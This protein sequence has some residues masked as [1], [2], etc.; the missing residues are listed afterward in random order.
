MG[1]QEIFA[2]N[3]IYHIYNR[4]TRKSKIFLDEAD[5]WRWGEL[6]WWCKT[7]NYPY[8]IYRYQLEQAKRSGRDP[9]EI[10]EELDRTNKFAVAPVQ[11]LAFAHMPNH[12]HLL[13]KQVTDEGITQFMHRVGTAYAAYFNRRYE[14]KGALYEGTFK[15][16]RM[17][18]DEQFLQV[19]RYIHLNPLAA[20]LVEKEELINYPKTSL[21]VYLHR[22]GSK[23]RVVDTSQ[24]LEVFG[25]NRKEL[26]EFTLAPIDERVIAELGSLTLDDDFGWYQEQRAR[27][28]QRQAE[29]VDR[30][31]RS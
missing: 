28:Q 20:G 29:V 17:R 30:L 16:V 23:S 24:V 9:Q 15:A 19:V 12:F 27:K 11:I 26:L 31:A 6:L 3:Q 25:N 13:L 2:N 18:T 7:Y 22:L 4:G 8:S 5:Y 21:S 10:I 1:L 14:L